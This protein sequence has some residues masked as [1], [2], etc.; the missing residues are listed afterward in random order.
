VAEFL[1]NEKVGENVEFRELQWDMHEP[2]SLRMAVI[3]MV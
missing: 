3:S 1:I 2:E